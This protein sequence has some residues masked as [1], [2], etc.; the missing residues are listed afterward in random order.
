MNRF[1]YSNKII[2]HE[3]LLNFVALVRPTSSIKYEHYEKLLLLCIDLTLCNII[4]STT[5]YNVFLMLM[6]FQMNSLPD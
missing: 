3:F 1:M 2:R 4:L 6:S 5:F